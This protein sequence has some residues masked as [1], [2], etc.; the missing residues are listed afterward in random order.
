MTDE[1]YKNL[2]YYLSGCFQIL[3]KNDF[4]LIENILP[5]SI[6]GDNLLSLLSN[7]NLKE[8]NPQ[9]NLTYNDVYLLAR[10]IIEKIDKNYLKYYDKLIESGELDFS[11]EHSYYDSNCQHNFATGKNIININRRFNYLD[12]STLVHEFMHYTNNLTNDCTI[13]RHILTEAISIYYGEFA[14]KY[15]LEKGIDKS[16]LWLNERLYDI[17]NS[18]RRFNKYNILLLAYSKFGNIDKNTYKMLNKFFLNIPSDDFEKICINALKILDK[19]SEETFFETKMKHGEIPN[20]YE[21]ILFNE[22]IKLVNI[23]YR[24]I[25]G[26]VIA[27]NA[28]QYSSIE[29]MTNLNNHVN[30][31]GVSL[32]NLLKLI[33]I[34]LKNLSLEPIEKFLNGEGK[35]K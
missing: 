22:L 28:L 1:M 9:D 4:F 34:E 25:F 33:N 6:M 15:L 2:N 26:T 32:N 10:E 30:D 35:T 19:K 27:Y 20:D 3:E 16:K 21:A 17:S 24:Y 31:L 5:I 18:L 13:N 7:Y 12:V 29:K 23:D 11:Y 14:K 8:D